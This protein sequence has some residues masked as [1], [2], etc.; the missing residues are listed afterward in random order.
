[1]VE[2]EKKAWVAPEIILI[3]DVKLETEFN[4]GG[5]GDLQLLGS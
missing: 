2:E 1:M 4:F 3:A 5:S